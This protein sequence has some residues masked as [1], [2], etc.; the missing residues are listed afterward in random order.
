MGSRRQSGFWCRTVGAWSWPGVCAPVGFGAKRCHTSRSQC[1]MSSAEGR[2]LACILVHSKKM[3]AAMGG[4]MAGSF[5]TWPPCKT[6]TALRFR[7]GACTVGPEAEF[8]VQGLGCR[9]WG[10]ARW[11]RALGARTN[12]PGRVALH[13]A[14]LMPLQCE[15][16][17]DDRLWPAQGML[18]V[19]DASAADAESE[20]DQALAQRHV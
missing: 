18:D 1:T 3:R 20:G 6:Q 11:L 2:A 19:V 13:D 9:E 4:H 15:R 16:P 10:G 7:W 17:A 12:W 8:R 5:S 14:W